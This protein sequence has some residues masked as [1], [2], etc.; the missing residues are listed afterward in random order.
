[1]RACEQLGYPLRRLALADGVGAGKFLQD[2]LKALQSFRP[3]MVLVLNHTGVD[4]GGVLLSILKKVGVPLASWFVDSPELTLGGREQLAGEGVCLF[5]WDK[6]AVPFLKEAGCKHTHYLPLATDPALFRPIKDRNGGAQFPEQLDGKVLFV[7]N[8]WVS[9]VQSCLSQLERGVFLQS[10]ELSSVWKSAAESI[11]SSK[12]P[13]VQQ[14]VE[15]CCPEEW[16]AY[17]RLSGEDKRT[18]DQLVIFQASRLWRIKCVGKL[19]K[20]T[21]IMGDS[22]WKEELQQG[23]AR[24]HMQYCSSVPYDELPQWYGRAA[25]N[26]NCTSLQMHTAVNQRVFDVPACGGFLLT[27]SRQELS[28][29]FAEDEV[30]TYDCES[31][32]PGKVQ[33]WLENPEERKQV[34]KKARKRILE[35]HTYV[36]RLRDMVQI[37]GQV[38]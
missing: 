13:H 33:Y 28:E 11:C 17:M 16:P 2:I 37:M 21:I 14:G 38:F 5:C 32:I 19:G 35:E 34:V 7:G 26:F 8:S 23:F 20:D 18:F 31:E 27:D 12:F 24:E 9:N 10:E 22:H 15:C 4:S 36:H 29:L 30:V 25:I 6:G 3:D 1:M